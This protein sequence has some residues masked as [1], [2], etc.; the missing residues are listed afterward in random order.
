M[1]DRVQPAPRRLV[2]VAQAEARQQL[3]EDHAVQ[4]VDQGPAEFTRH[5]P[6][7]R[8]PV[9]GAP[10]ERERVAVDPGVERGDLPRDRAVPVDDGAEHIERENP[11][12]HHRHPAAKPQDAGANA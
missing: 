9:A 2:E 3:V 5:H 4:V 10:G 7:H 11:R 8:R 6:L 12:R 1:P